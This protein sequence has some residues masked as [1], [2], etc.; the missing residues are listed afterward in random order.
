MEIL[1]PF[2]FP[3]KFSVDHLSHDGI[4]NS[5]LVS[6]TAVTAVYARVCL[7][8]MRLPPQAPVPY[9]CLKPGPRAS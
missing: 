1:F 3:A 8:S 6:K 7:L 9:R 4:C 2:L 5:G